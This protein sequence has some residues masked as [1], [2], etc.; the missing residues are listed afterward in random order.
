MEVRLS[1]EETEKEKEKEKE[2]G[3][4]TWRQE[5]VRSRNL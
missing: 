5:L 2:D 1:T 3:I 4:D